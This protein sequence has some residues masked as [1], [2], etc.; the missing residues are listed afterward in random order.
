M[1]YFKVLG[2]VFGLVAFLKP[3]YMHV[4]PWDENAFI[5]KAYAE[6]R[7]K[8]IVWVSLIGFLLVGFTWYKHFTSDIQYSIVITLLF[9]LTLIKGLTFVFNYKAFYLWVS[10]MLSKNNGKK[11]ILVDVAAGVLGLV[12]IVLSLKLY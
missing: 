12:I 6:K 5:K 1:N 7:P 3:F 11:I 2:L 9:S 10:K 8:W 4:L